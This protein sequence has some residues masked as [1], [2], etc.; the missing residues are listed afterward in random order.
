MEEL[1]AALY[2]LISRLDDRQPNRGNS[3][4]EGATKPFLSEDTYQRK[5][6]AMVEARLEKLE[7]C[8]MRPLGNQTT[9]ERL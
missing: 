2:W 9:R 4:V 8:C 3:C 7:E 1:T 5:H 6:Q